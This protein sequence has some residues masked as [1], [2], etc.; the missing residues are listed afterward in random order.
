MNYLG[1]A[2]KR[3]HDPRL[4]R[5]HGCYIADLQKRGTLSAAFLRSPHAHAKITDINF[6]EAKKLPGVVAVFGADGSSELPCLPLIF[7]QPDLTGVTQRPFNP[8]VH[9]VGEP[10]AMVIAESRYIAEDALDLITVQYEPLPAVAKLEDADLEGAALAHEHLKSNLAIEFNKST[11]DAMAAMQ[12]ADIVVSH[13]FEIGRVSCLPIETRG[14]M[15]EWKE[16]G[17]EPV[18]EVHAATQSQHEMRNILAKLLNIPENQIRV[19]APDVG[20]AFGAKAIFYVEDFLIPWAARLVGAPV[21]WIEDR[22]EHLMSSIHEREQIHE[23]TLGIS[24]EGKIIAVHDKMLANTGAY[25]PWGVI[26]PIMTATLIPGPYKVPNYLCEARVL[27]TNTVPL[28]P[29]RGAG[30]PQAALILNRLLDLAAKKLGIDPVEI[31][32]R[33]LIEKNEFP[34]NTGLKARDG[35]PQIYDSG[36]FKKLLERVTELGEYDHWR[37]QQQKYLEEGRFIGIG[38]VS[39]IEN[40]GYGTFEGATVRIEV[41]GDISVHTG[42]ATQGQ[43]HETTL[44][45]IA[46][47]VFN[48]PLEKVNVREG[49]TALISYA[50]GTFASRV[51][52]V[53]GSAVYNAAVRVKNKAL[54]I[55]SNILDTDIDDL[56]LTGGYIQIRDTD[57]KI[58]LGELAHQARGVIPGSTFSFPVSPGLEVTEYFSPKAAAV[59]SMA[60]LA[61]VEVDPDSYRIKILNYATVHDNGRMLNPLVVKGQIQGGVANGLGNAL[62][63]EIIYDNQGQI[64]TSSLMDY[65]VPTACEIPDMKIDHIETLSPLN[66]LGIKGAGESGT[67]PVPAVIQSAV[68]DALSTFD[69]KLSKIPVKPSQLCD[70]VSRSMV[71]G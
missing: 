55:A 18:L 16:L 49:D 10:V 31:K 59:T 44:A 33:N 15:A 11:G 54:K 62:Y 41:N 42:A 51:A 70:L 71:K 24:S 57:Y 12:E 36:D 68:E 45:Q 52:T 46:A 8:F 22:L 63:E 6:E 38:V 37:H 9:H 17:P 25:V 48:I 21:Q 1:K 65:L 69:I 53:V 67:I 66:P 3:K 35:S 60:D 64:L 19:I 56:E 43:S 50:T 61:V 26:V 32:R 47:E 14:L 39:S 29:F 4:L 58:H 13:R 40:T 5:G 2:L 27:Y 7:P 30:R 28:A 23:A 20:G 34:Y